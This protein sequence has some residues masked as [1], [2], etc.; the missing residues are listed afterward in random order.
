VSVYNPP[1]EEKEK[2]RKDELGRSSPK[3]SQKI[4]DF[5]SDSSAHL[6]KPADSAV[7]GTI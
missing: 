2:D 4:F 6:K 7:E 1:E 3:K 5:D